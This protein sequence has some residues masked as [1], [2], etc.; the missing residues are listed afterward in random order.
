MHYAGVGCEMDAIC[1]IAGRRGL[2]VVEDNAHGL[3]GKY[4]GQYLGTFGALATQSFHETKN[5]T[6]GEGGSALL[7]NNESLFERAEVIREKGTNRS[8]FFLEGRW[9]KLYPGGAKPIKLS[10]PRICSPPFCSAQLEHSGE[11]QKQ[12]QAIWERYQAALQGWAAGRAVSGSAAGARALRTALSHAFYLVMPSPGRAPGVHCASETAE[13]FERFLIM[14][15]L[16]LSPMGR[17][18]GGREGTCPVTEDTSDRLVR[19]PFYNSL[20]PAQQDRVIEAVLE[21]HG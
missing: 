2:V 8:R 18:F 14:W 10:A 15:P 4:R 7:V 21:F 19:L 20:N 5:I 6:C 11:I 1:R 3:F 12:R 16:H 17:Q 13:Y 9:T